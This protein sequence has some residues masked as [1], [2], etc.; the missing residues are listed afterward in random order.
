MPE[1]PKAMEWT[2][3]RVRRLWD[4]ESAH[5]ERY[6]AYK[7]SKSLVSVL[8]RHLRGARRVLDY[9]CGRGFLAEK[10]LE[11]GVDVA[12]ADDSPRSV[13]F[14]EERFRGQ[15][16]FLGASTVDDL[17]KSG[18]RFDAIFVIE[19]IEHLDDAALEELFER[20]RSVASPGATLIITTPNAEKLR[21]SEVYCP[22]CDQRFHRWGHV[23]TWTADSLAAYLSSL[24]LDMVETIEGR[25]AKVVPGQPLRSL[26]GRF[27]KLSRGAKRPHLVAVCRVPVD[28]A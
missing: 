6:F 26:W 14:V 8:K 2:A 11:I 22:S 5:P 1:E 12:A 13:A 27:Q 9:G 7:Y 17:Q 23:R 21:A 3:D 20:V 4:Y 15:K 18:E 24:G 25:F 16:G 10:L 19:V 28:A